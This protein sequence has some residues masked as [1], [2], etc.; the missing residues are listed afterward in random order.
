MNIKDL[1]KQAK[2]DEIERK[3]KALEDCRNTIV[4][5]I[6][7]KMKTGI[8][9][10]NV[11]RF[12][13]NYYCK[14]EDLMNPKLLKNPLDLKFIGFYSLSS[15][16]LFILSF[17]NKYYELYVKYFSDQNQIKAVEISEEEAK[18]LITKFIEY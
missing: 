5:N 1:E 18:E 10:K 8:F 11:V 2:K 7:N 16:N 3:R 4:Y 15:D 14:M 17:N 13:T 6:K 9:K 12:F